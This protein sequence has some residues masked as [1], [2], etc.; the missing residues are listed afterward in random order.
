MNLGAMLRERDAAGRPLRVALVG[1]GKFGTMWLAQ[2]V[3][4]PGVHVSR[5]RTSRRTGRGR[6]S[7]PRGSPPERGARGGARGRGAV[8]RH[9]RDRRRARR[10]CARASRGPRG[11]DREPGGGGRHRPR[12][13]ARGEARRDGE[14]R[15]GRRVRA[16]PRA[17][18]PEAGV[19]VLAR[20]RRPAGAHLRA[21]GL[22][23]RVRAAGR[24]RGEGDE[25]LPRYHASTP[26]PSGR[27]TASPP[28]TR[29]AAG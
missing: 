8:G 13:R 6:R 2:A 16:A 10:S 11:R 7:R 9:L 25:Y 29:R 21:G 18:L 12:L 24:G 5:S 28:R 3:R 15:G 17:S 26:A 23:A 4:T 1:A 14:R 20:V 19:V 22:G 27:T